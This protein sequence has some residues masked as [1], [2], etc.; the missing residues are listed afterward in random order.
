M[1]FELFDDGVRVL[2]PAKLNLHLEV[3]PARA[4][5]FHGIDSI[6]QTVTLFDELEFEA[7]PSTAIE[8]DEQGIVA[9]EDN[10]VF[11]AA[12]RLQDWARAQGAEC[13]GARIRLRKRIPQ[14]AGLGG[15]SSDAA[16]TLLA[17]CRLWRLSPSSE[18]LFELA[19]ELGSDVPFFLIGGTCRCQGRG[20]LVTPLSGLFTAESP[21]FFVLVYPR[22]VVP[23]SL[24]YK[25]LDDL[26][27]AGNGLT[28]SAALDSIS[29]T[30]LGDEL[31]RGKLFFNRLESTVFPAYPELQR[32]REK[33]AVEPFLATRLSGSG[34][35]VYGVCG[36]A[37]DAERIASQLCA[38]VDADVYSVRSEH[39]VVEPLVWALDGGTAGG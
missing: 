39:A 25:G 14:G 11:R 27:G 17:L 24:V 36:N 5:G 21:L 19:A 1:R 16:A 9:R 33:M 29:P 10:L 7:L 4:D 23:T 32:L 35:T 34:S 30:A 26:G 8:L 22:V 18:V 2:A 6:F 15:G 13:G 20:E 3:G 28:P 12:R 37:L 31:R 38:V